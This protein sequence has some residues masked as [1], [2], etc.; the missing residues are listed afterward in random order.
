[1]SI[2]ASAPPSPSPE[3]RESRNS[4]TPQLGFAAGARLA[5]VDRIARRA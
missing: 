4:S 1:M 2:A 3:A 5:L